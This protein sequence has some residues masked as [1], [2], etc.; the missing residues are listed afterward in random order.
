MTF[1]AGAFMGVLALAVATTAAAQ[2]PRG[3]IVRLDPQAN[4][5]VLENGQMYR[6]TATTSVYV[7]TQP[8]AF[9]DLRP[10]QTVLIRGGE[11][12]TYEGGRYITGAPPAS[13][14]T[15]SVVIATPPPAVGIRQTVY[16]RVTDVDRDGEVEIET[17]SDS[18]KVR[19]SREAASQIRKG[20]TVQIDVTVVPPGTPAASPRAR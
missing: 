17:D 9:A 18:F 6:T 10:G 2:D 19:L 7:D 14:P 1:R 4:V 12:V 11:A 20:D 16:G 5:I 3:T 8:A 13:P 15:P